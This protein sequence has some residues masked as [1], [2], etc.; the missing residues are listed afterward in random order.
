MQYRSEKPTNSR[1][2]VSLTKNEKQSNAS[3]RIFSS[4]GAKYSKV[5]RTYVP[6]SSANLPRR[7]HNDSN[8]QKSSSKYEKAKSG[9]KYTSSSS[10]ILQQ[11][12]SKP[13][14]RFDDRNK[15]L[16]GDLKNEE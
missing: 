5:P 8:S 10:K 6:I 15:S 13:V 11:K 9:H 1:A 7:Y 14:S 2:R 4:S 12:N 16:N 3:K